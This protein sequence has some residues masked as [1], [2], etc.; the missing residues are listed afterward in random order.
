VRLGQS[1]SAFD[2]SLRHTEQPNNCSANTG[3]RI[4]AAEARRL[5]CT[6]GIIPMVLGGKSQVLDVGRKRRFH[7]E[8]MRVAIHRNRAEIREKFH[9]KRATVLSALTLSGA[10]LLSACGDDGG[11]SGDSGGG[12]ARH[13]GPGST[14]SHSA[15]WRTHREFG[16]GLPTY[17]LT[18]RGV[19]L[20]SRS[21]HPVGSGIGERTKT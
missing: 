5:A 7:T 18:C 1:N 19:E 2:P 10:L 9:S 15:A 21:A 12:G 16:P 4:S 3:G 13:L 20:S 17:V 6:A 14:D 8:G 11:S